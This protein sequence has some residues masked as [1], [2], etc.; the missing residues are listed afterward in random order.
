MATQTSNPPKAAK[1]APAP[2]IKPLKPILEREN[3]IIIGAGIL[4]LIVGYVLMSGGH[5]KPTEWKT[6]E[7]YSFRR[8][9][10]APITVILGYA[11]IAFGLM[12]KTK[13]QETK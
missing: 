8:I 7:I 2:Q 13:Q 11:V 6:E 9:T 4:L 12:K 5:Q 3:F 10:I 1:A